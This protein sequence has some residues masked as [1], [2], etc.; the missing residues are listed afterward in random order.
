MSN[1]SEVTVIEETPPE[2]EITE[3]QPIPGKQ[4]FSFGS[5]SPILSH[6]NARPTG[7]SGGVRVGGGGVSVGGGGAAGG[8]RGSRHVVGGVG[9]A[10]GAGA[11][12]VDD[13]KVWREK[14]AALF[15]T[16]KKIT[17]LKRDLAKL[18]G[19][20]MD[21]KDLI[22]A[23]RTNVTKE[24][25]KLSPLKLKLEEIKVRRTNTERLIGDV[26]ATLAQYKTSL[27]TSITESDQLTV[28]LMEIEKKVQ[29]GRKSVV[30]HVTALEVLEA[31]VENKKTLI[32]DLQEELSC[33]EAE[34]TEIYNKL[35]ND[36]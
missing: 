6:Q 20:I 9:G 28:T 1:G 14:T 36:D 4:P 17:P 12:V 15:D 8:M 25:D 22:D 30:N 21:T 24:D 11:G 34:A 13:E 10:A 29:D 32:N 31:D 7:R 33:L 19:D 23:G 35:G 2:G 3:A 18:N 27:Q 5:T 26:E 16:K